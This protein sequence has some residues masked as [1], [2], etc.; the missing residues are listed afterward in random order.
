MLYFYERINQ[1]GFSL[2]DCNDCIH[3]KFNKNNEK[4]KT[5]HKNILSEP[6]EEKNK[7]FFD[8]FNSDAWKMMMSFISSYI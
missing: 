1:F 8:K 3:S 6:K 5:L 2:K 7:F 4:Y